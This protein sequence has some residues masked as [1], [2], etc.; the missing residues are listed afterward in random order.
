ME[1]S[2]RWAVSNQPIP[3]CRYIEELMSVLPQSK[4]HHE[5]LK[6][7][8]WGVVFMVGAVWLWSGIGNHNPI[9][10]ARLMFYGKTIQGQILDTLEDAEDAEGGGTN[11]YSSI[12]YS[13]TLPNGEEIKSVSKGGKL[14]PEWVDLKNPVPVDVEYLPSRP[15][16]NRLEGEGSRSLFGWLVRTAAS[17]FLL[18]MFIRPGIA[19]ARAGLTALRQAGRSGAD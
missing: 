9:D 6:T 14:P 4:D 10:D 7:A 19:M 1:R 18:V 2:K 17:I 13:F 5:A 8:A 3:S 16:I 11:W 15:S 12:S